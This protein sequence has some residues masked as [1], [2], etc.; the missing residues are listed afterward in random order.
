MAPEDEKVEKLVDDYLERRVDR[1]GFLKRAGALG[2]S[3]SAASA[4]LA[5]CGG[6]EEEAAAPPPAE[7]APAATEPAA[8]EP[9]ATEPAATEPAATG[10]SEASGPLRLRITTDI[11]NLDPAY[12]PATSDEIAMFGVYEGLV[13][14]APG[15]WDLVNQL[16]ETFEPSADGLQFAVQ[17]QGGD[18]V[19]RRLRRGHGRGR[20]VLLRAHRRP[21]DAPARPRIPLHGRLGAPSARGESRRDVRGHDHP[22]GAVRPAADDDATGAQRLDRVEEGRRGEG[23]GLRDEPD[24]DGP[25]R[26]RRVEPEARRALP[27]LRGLQRRLGGHARNDLGRAHPDPDRGG[28]GRPRSRSR[29][30]SST[31]ESW[32]STPSTASRRTTTSPSRSARRWTTPGSG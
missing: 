21:D 22:Q 5:A 12:Y 2:I 10:P 3:L 26:V 29:P 27:A 25:L 6:E 9:A 31:S 20:Q 14:Y 8:T 18:P 32:R 30:A 7:P 13:R 15:T 23:R 19:P 17:A 1:R 28:R 24:R 11:I 4:L 16:A